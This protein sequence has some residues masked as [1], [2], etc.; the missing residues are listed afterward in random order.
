MY[1]FYNYYCTIYRYLEVKKAWKFNYKVTCKV[2]LQRLKN[3]PL[4]I[5]T[6]IAKAV[7][8]L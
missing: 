3:I 6:N 1:T 8:E 7:V 4:N 2:F 5:T